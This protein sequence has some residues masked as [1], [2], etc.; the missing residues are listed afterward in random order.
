MHKLE[1]N[2]HV[3]VCDELRE[4]SQE[5][6]DE[7]SYKEMHSFF[8][9]RGYNL[10]ESALHNHTRLRNPK[11]PK[12]TLLPLYAEFYSRKLQRPITAEDIL[13]GHASL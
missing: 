2:R 9:E 4:L 7:L 3:V 5:L 10:S 12:E 6:G 11:C 8:R 13:T 1:N